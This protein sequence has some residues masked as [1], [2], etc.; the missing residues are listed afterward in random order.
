MW[1]HPQDVATCICTEE[2]AV[3]TSRQLSVDAVMLNVPNLHDK[4]YNISV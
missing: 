1:Y 2:G 4:L 3:V